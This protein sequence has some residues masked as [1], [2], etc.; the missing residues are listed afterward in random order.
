MNIRRSGSSQQL[1]TQPAHAALAARIMR[2][3]QPGHFPD[4]SR[5]SSILKAVEHHDIGWA[6]V[7]DI[8]V[9]DE[10]TQQLLD[11]NELP[12]ALK[13]ETSWRGIDRLRDDPYAAA[14]VSQHRLHVYRRHSEQLDWIGFFAGV[15]AARDAYLRASGAGSIEQL[16]RD[17]AFVRAGDLASLAFCNNWTNTPDDGCGYSMRVDGTTLTLVPDPFAGRV[18]EISIEAREIPNQRFA[19][20]HDARTILAGAPVVTLKGT[21]KGSAV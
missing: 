20:A 17:Y 19:S 4:S 6:E 8:L 11:F 5:K 9:V 3:W 10:T 7:D 1:I 18:I 21:V 12:D 15:T 14:L 13:R 2:Q 16:L